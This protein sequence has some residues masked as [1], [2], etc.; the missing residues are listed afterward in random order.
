[1]PPSEDTEK[2]RKNPSTLFLPLHSHSRLLMPGCVSLDEGQGDSLNFPVSMQNHMNLRKL[3]EGVSQKG[4]THK[5]EAL[6]RIYFTRTGRSREKFSKE[7][8]KAL[9]A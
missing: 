2:K 8:E 7:R 3:L 1:M 6:A 5:V 9:P 4:E